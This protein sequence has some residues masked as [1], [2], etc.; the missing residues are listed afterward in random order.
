VNLPRLTAA[1]SIYDPMTPLT[2]AYRAIATGKSMPVQNALILAADSCVRTSPNCT[3]SV[4]PRTLAL[5]A[6]A[7]LTSVVGGDASAYV[8]AGYPF[9]LPRYRA[10]SCVLDRLGASSRRGMEQRLIANLP[11]AASSSS[12]PSG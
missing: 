6:R 1:A 8:T 9:P 3:W 12:S 11:D 10:V 5:I 2:F 7:S 4:Q